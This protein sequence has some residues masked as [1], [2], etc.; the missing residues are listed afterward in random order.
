[1]QYSS[2]GGYNIGAGKQ[3]DPYI[4]IEQ[5]AVR[6]AERRKVGVLTA[7][8]RFTDTDCWID[9]RQDRIEVIAR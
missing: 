6:R 8:E 7:I 5:S 3:I 4:I 2:T 1:M 9:I